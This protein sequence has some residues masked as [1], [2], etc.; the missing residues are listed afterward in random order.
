MSVFAKN[1]CLLILIVGCVA[2]CSKSDVPVSKGIW[3]PSLKSALLR[4]RHESKPIL[5]DFG[6]D[7]CKPCK[8]MHQEVFVDSKIQ[9]HLVNNF[10]PVLIDATDMTPALAKLLQNYQVNSL[11]SVV[12]LRPDG[13]FLAG[14]TLVGFSGV[15]T[16]NERIYAVLKAVSGT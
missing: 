10:I 14:Q 2:S 16:L 15:E 13:D 6:A 9:K 3:E 5:I 8:R 1:L 7:W 4:A 11:P 12:F